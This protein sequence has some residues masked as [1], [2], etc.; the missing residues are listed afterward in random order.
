[1]KLIFSLL[2]LLTSMAG[3]SKVECPTAHSINDVLECLKNKHLLVQ[4]KDLEVNATGS[5]GLALSQRPNPVVNVSTVHTRGAKQTEIVISQELDLAGKRKSLRKKGELI[6]ETKKNELK[7]SSEQVI[8]EVLLAIQRLFYLDETLKVNREVSRSFLNV[9][10]ALKKRPALTPEQEASLLN[11]RLQQAEVNNII[12]LLEDEEEEIFLFFFLNGGYRKEEIRKVMKGQTH[13]LE[14]KRE[15]TSNLSLN[16]QRIGL[17]TKLAKEELNFQ[18]SLPW[19]GVSIGPMFMN[20]NMEYRSEKL[21]GV[22][23]SFPIPVWQTNK[24][25]KAIASVSLANTKTQFDLLKRRED[26]QK[27]SLNLRIDALKSTLMK[28][29]SNDEL[30]K[31]H[32]RIEKLYSQGLITP[33]SF[34]ESHR[35][36]RDVTSSKLQLKEKILRQSIEYHRLSGVLSEVKL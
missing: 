9:M 19:D 11:F 15:I 10:A 14:L 6:H 29:P 21:Y 18:K 4:L 16:L 20:D 34:L 35:I 22:S 3:H 5:L 1:M 17:E 27:N 13:P 30:F 25:G 36:W 8:E 28:L 32:K 26:L 7:L 2:M 31:T 23:L 24:V 12:S 33:T